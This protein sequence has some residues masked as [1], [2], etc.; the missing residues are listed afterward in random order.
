MNNHKVKLT[1]EFKKQTVKAISGIIF[2][3]LSYLVILV[4]AMLLTALCVYLGVL[5]ILLRPMFITLAL[6]IGMAS[7]G[8]LVLFFLLKFVFKSSKTDLSHLYPIKK[9]D[10]P[11]LF[12]LIEE[13]VNEVKTDFPKKV[14]LSADVNASVFY[15]SSFWSMFFPV[16]KNLQIGMGLIN[17]VTQSELKAIL[18]H[19]FG[20]FSQRTMKVGSYVY[21]VNQVIF[22]LLYD[23]E[24]YDKLMQRWANTSGYFAI[25][26]SFS[27]KIINQIKEV[28]TSLY[29]VVNKNYLALSREMEFHADEIAASVTGYEPLQKSLIRLSLADHS[30]SLVSSFYDEKIPE[31][32]RSNNFYEEQMFAMLFLSAYNDFN[33]QN[34]LPQ[35]S[36]DELNR[37]NKSKLV[38]TNQWASHPST[39]E[40]IARLEATGLKATNLNNSPACDLLKNPSY[41]QQQLTNLLFKNVTFQ[42]KP[43][44]LAFSEFEE[45]FKKSFYKN[46]FSKIY[47][48]YYDNKSPLEFDIEEAISD[49][50]SFTME[51]LFSDEKVDLVYTAVSLQNDIDILKQIDS[52]V[53]KVKTF[54]YDGVKY[55]A[56][57]S[58]SLIKKLEE[59]LGKLNNLIK[60]NDQNIYRFFIQLEQKTSEKTGRLAKYYND[61]WIYDQQIAGKFELYNELI[62]DLSF[63]SVTTPFE[64]II[65]NFK[66]IEPKEERLKA[67]IKDILEQEVFASEIKNNTRENFEKYISNKIEYFD[68]DHY[69]DDE[70][71]I[72]YTALNDFIYLVSRGYFLYKKQILTYQEELLRGN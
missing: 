37:F 36:T 19:E 57:E 55:Q 68:T 70:L 22:N 13:I 17:T 47:N 60:E 35:V 51:L 49:Q 6:G 41:T 63:V 38:I 44:S 54:D 1:E 8:V 53:I 5:I 56:T 27:L 46:T 39:E 26:V 67:Q 31:N 14:Y 40:R 3:I 2:F 65:E 43:Q 34:G 12:N 45:E 58:N 33:I 11:Q 50:K 42:E 72:F 16:R 23:N 29:E 59:E 9:E 69:K 71:N 66:A 28:L 20:H 15:D 21:N 32:I 48:S 10:E 24:G 64:N 30:F 18:A 62:S 7:L 25:F 61:F 52:N 4:L